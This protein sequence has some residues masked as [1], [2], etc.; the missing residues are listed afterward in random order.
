MCRRDSVILLD[1]YTDQLPSYLGSLTGFEHF[2]A[3]SLRLRQ[4]VS[5]KKYFLAARLRP[6]S[7]PLLQAFPG[8][9]YLNIEDTKNR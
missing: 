9:V 7:I 5:S 8:P 1:I 6:R 4:E 2:A 3:T